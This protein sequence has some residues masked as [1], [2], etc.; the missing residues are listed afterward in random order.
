MSKVKK[1]DTVKVHYTGKLENG[2]VFDSSENREPL[3]FKMGAGQLIPGFEK[4]VMGMEEGESKEF[5][6]DWE[7]SKKCVSL[8]IAVHSPGADRRKGC[9]L[10]N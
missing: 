8:C 7:C 3:E 2:Q 5:V 10:Q 4:E 6:L 9:A 1:E